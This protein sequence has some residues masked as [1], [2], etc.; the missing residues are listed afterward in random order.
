MFT[1]SPT[2]SVSQKIKAVRTRTHKSDSLSEHVMCHPDTDTDTRYKMRT[3][4]NPCFFLFYNIQDNASRRSMHLLQ[5]L[6]FIEN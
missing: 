2:L 6:D 4:G 5:S 3:E 1:P